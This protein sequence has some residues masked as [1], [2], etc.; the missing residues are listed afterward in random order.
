MAKAPTPTKVPAQ[1]ST[2]LKEVS[3]G[4]AYQHDKH[5]SNQKIDLSAGLKKNG[6]HTYGFG[7]ANGSIAKA[8]V[9]KSS[10][11]KGKG[12]ATNDRAK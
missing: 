3:K 2:S 8:G 5:G 1:K 12:G 10:I 9:A 6:M 4:T 11:L 7:P